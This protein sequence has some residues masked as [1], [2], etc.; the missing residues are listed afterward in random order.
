MARVE[1]NVPLSIEEI[2]RKFGESYVKY[3][4]KRREAARAIMNL[5]DQHHKIEVI[6]HK[7]SFTNW[8]LN[9]TSAIPC[10]L[11]VISVAAVTLPFVKVPNDSFVASQFS[12]FLMDLKDANDLP[13]GLCC[14]DSKISDAADKI[15]NATNQAAGIAKSYCDTTSSGDRVEI[16]ARQE[17]H[18]RHLAK[19]EQEAQQL[20][21]EISRALNEIGERK[22]QHSQLIARIAG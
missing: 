13:C 11:N 14:L 7:E 8:R 1:R 15:L 16:S 9:S 4:G 12:S 2:E 17:E 21:Q 18:N 10:I 6:A 3:L 5:H 20:D 19:K 22:S